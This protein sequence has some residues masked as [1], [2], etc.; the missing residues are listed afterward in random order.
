MR[1]HKYFDKVRVEFAPRERGGA[2][3]RPSACGARPP[4]PRRHTRGRRVG[5]YSI[6]RRKCETNYETNYDTKFETNCETNYETKCETNF[7]LR[8]VFANVCANITRRPCLSTKSFRPPDLPAKF[9]YPPGLTFARSCS[10][11]KNYFSPW[12]GCRGGKTLTAEKK[13]GWSFFL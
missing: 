11:T 4:S 12:P 3:G 13:V 10:C 6:G 5:L 1:A 9:H 2:P 8:K 7:K